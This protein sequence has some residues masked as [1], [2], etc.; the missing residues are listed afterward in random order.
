MSVLLSTLAL[1]LILSAF[2]SGSETAMMT[3]NRYRLKHLVRQNHRGA[4]K[5]HELLKRPERLLGLILIGNNF[6]N[7]LAAT[8]ATIIAIRLGG[9][10]LIAPIIGT[11]TL[12]VLVFSEV[13]PKTLGS[14]R[15]EFL[16]FLSAWVYIPLLKVFYPLV[17]MVNA[18]SNTLLWIARIKPSSDKQKEV[19][20]KD[21]LKNAVADSENLLPPRYRTMLLA[22]L[23]LESATVDDIMTPRKE[24]IGIDIEESLEVIQRQLQ[25]TQ[26]D[27]LPVY[28]KNIDR[29]IGFLPCRH[30]LAD[31]LQQG[32]FDKALIGEN[33]LKPFFIPTGTS[34]HKQ[35]HIFK[36]EKLQIGLVV[37]EYG[38]V[39]GLIT[40]DDLLQEI[41]G[42]LIVEESDIKMQKDG[43]YL[44]DASITVRELN[45]VTHW[46]LPT[47]GPKTLNGLIIEYM[48]TIPDIGTSIKLHDHNLE[49]VQRDERTVKLVRF[50]PQ[51]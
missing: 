18:F 21:E 15:P 42:E 5:A 35:I 19:Q 41:A 10:E 25:T 51:K 45:R 38:D 37:D 50:Y 46:N 39:Q 1:L 44:V 49:I 13:T 48:E 2:F 3:L 12:V 27:L 33:L 30:L 9:D 29:I 28:K 36:C 32:Q 22:M 40:L 20:G 8:L 47:E 4:V 14:L 7:I 34:I 26:H 24:I 11:L 17:W 6:V 16:A 31:V 23:E 43:S